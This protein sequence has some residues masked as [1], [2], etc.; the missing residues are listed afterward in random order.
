M[1]RITGG[2]LAGRRFKAPAGMNTRPTSDRV[3][4]ALFAILGGRVQVELAADLFAGSGGLGL[5]ALSRGAGHC[6]FV[7]RQ[8]QVVKVLTR[9]LQSLGLWER[10][11]VIKTDAGA[12]GP[13]LLSRGACSLVLADPPYDQG[14]VTRVCRLAGPGGLLAPGGWLVIEHSPRERPAQ[15]PGLSLEDRRAYGQTEISFLYREP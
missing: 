7:E 9:N 13:R 4:E 8:R 14:E 12:P 1:L 11:T 3:K 6:I 2:H 5:E 15:E 10:A